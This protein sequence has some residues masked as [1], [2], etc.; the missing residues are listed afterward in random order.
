MKKVALIM[1][2]GKGERF[3]P[4]S[5]QNL[6]KQFLS[7]ADNGRSMIQLTVDRILPLVEFEDIFV[8]TNENYKKVVKIQLPELP[9]RNII[10][11]PISRNTAPCIGLGAIH[12]LRKYKD[13]IML[14]LPSDHMISQNQLYIRTLE[15]AAEVAI[16]KNN[17]VTI[18]ITPTYAETGYGY[19]KYLPYII[20]GKCFK[21]DSF[22]EKPSIEKANDYV[23]SGEYLWNSGQFI[24][25]VSTIMQKISEY[26]PDLYSGLQRINN[27]I[28]TDYEKKVLESEFFAFKPESIDYGIMEKTT[29]IYTIAG[30]F[31][32][33]DVGSWLAI[34][35]INQKDRNDNIISGNVIE[36][37][38]KNSIIQGGK[39]LISLIGV[40]NMVVVDSDDVVLIC[41]KNHVNDIKKIIIKLKS[42]NL[43]SYY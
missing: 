36:I 13:A 12:V 18:G 7:F 30:S 28:G 3:W 26:L 35:R 41:Q 39:R 1:A 17:I 21:V 38:T 2:G 9:E 16:E 33:D 4:K 14:V 22:V 32:W 27:A 24:W 23:S 8:V 19:I 31:G 10:C 43:S 15:D 20:N 6:P 25:K 37:D 5:R 42:E 40:E 29:S 34:S 11:E